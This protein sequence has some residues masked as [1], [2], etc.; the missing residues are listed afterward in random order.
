W[1]HYRGHAT[2]LGV[3]RPYDGPFFTHSEEEVRARF[4]S[5]RERGALIVIAHPFEEPYAFKFDT[6]RLPFDCLEVWNGPMRESNLRAVSYW[7]EMLA[8]GKKV[9][10]T[11]GSDYHRD[12]LFQI[13][14]GPCMGVYA[15][16]DSP[17]ALLAAVREGHS[18]VTFAPNGPTL[19]VT[20]E[21]AILGDA[22]A[23]RSGLAMRLRAE[24]LK[25]GD[26]VKV[27]SGQG[28]RD[29]FRAPSDGALDLEIPVEAPGFAVVQI[30]RT[31]LPG[32]PPLPALLSNPIYFEE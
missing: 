15:A 27:V 11:G 7:L 6:A 5:A 20:C 26:S 9:A 19:A 12:G 18:F 29:I 1:T 32:I 30:W 31:F 22:V 25:A 3:D 17:Q 8:A 23:W 14:G 28:S 10:I 13:L 4:V 24:G 16:S 2:F 21:G